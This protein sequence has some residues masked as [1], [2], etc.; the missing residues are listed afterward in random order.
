M[1]IFKPIFSGK[2]FLL[3]MGIKPWT[4]APVCAVLLMILSGCTTV[5]GP[6]SG[7]T[8]VQAGN[9]N[10]T[11]VPNY[12]VDA[13]WPGELPEK[14]ILGQVAGIAVDQN[15]HVWLVHRPR[16]LTEHEA[17]AVQN[18][19]TA[20]CCVPAPSVIE[21]DANGNFVQA[22]G[23]PSWDQEMET[24]IEPPYDWPQNEH[25]IFVDAEDNIWLGGN[26]GNDHIV[27]KMSKDGTYLMTIGQMNETGGSN[28]TEQLGQP[29][30][31]F[32]DTN[33]RE[34][35]IADGYGNRRV[36]VFDMDTGIYKRHWGAYGTMPGDDEL[37]TY[38]PDAQPLQD[39]SG[40]V[41]A[42]ELTS[43]GLLYVAD[44][45]SNRIQVFEQDGTFVSETLIAP[46]TL[47]QGSVWDIE[48]SGFADERW[49]FVSDGHNKK[50]WIIERDGMNIVG[51]FGRGGRQ[52]GQFEWVHNI[53][54]DSRGNIYTSEVNTG[55]RVQKFRPVSK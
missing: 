29:A 8:S 16:T 37:P 46:W 48:S 1:N 5:Q 28:N 32:V 17:A 27:L 40:P 18:P 50:V 33:A 49:L 53:A 9:N 2:K 43:D 45:S 39:F 42:L 23:G 3:L 25:G 34:A 13:S 21:F 20:E 14:W 52:A 44:R 4:T 24:W 36:I 7:S 11:T 12:E 35:F 51:D 31:I 47:D 22:W 19:P 26:G 30:D 6:V 54:A 10:F 41:H 38:D 55:K 15:D